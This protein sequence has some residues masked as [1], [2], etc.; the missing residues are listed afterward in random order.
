M[1]L[2]TQSLAL[3]GNQPTLPCL[4]FLYLCYILFQSGNRHEH[5]IF[6][7]SVPHLA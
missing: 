1:L 2:D 3:N 5:G 7:I 6:A 4:D